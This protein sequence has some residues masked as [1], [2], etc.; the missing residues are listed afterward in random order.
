M[1]RKTPP[2]ELHPP[3]TEARFK[4]FLKSGLRKMSTRWPPAQE[5]MKLHR[6]PYTGDDKRTKWEYQCSDCEQW[7]KQKE[8]HR[9]HIEAVGGFSQDWE[10]W[11]EELGQIAERMFCSVDGF[12]LL[13]H[14]CHLRRTNEQRQEKKDA[15]KD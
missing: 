3:W 4:S 1:G 2:C 15:E 5:I 12:Q 9:D 11:P 6:R 10:K 8:I 14:S 13:C 7:F